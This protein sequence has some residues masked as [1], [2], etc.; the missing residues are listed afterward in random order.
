MSGEKQCGL[1]EQFTLS[2]ACRNPTCAAGPDAAKKIH[3]AITFGVTEV[4]PLVDMGQGWGEV[5]V[6]N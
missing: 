2:S 4:L 3:A 5:N 6:N 1:M